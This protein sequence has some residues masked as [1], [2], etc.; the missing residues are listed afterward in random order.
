MYAIR[1]YYEIESTS[2]FESEKYTIEI[3]SK[4]QRRVLFNKVVLTSYEEDKIYTIMFSIAQSIGI[5]YYSS[6]SEYLLEETRVY[7][8]QLETKGRVDLKGRNNFV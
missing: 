7:T 5:G 8:T 1:S 4:K 6:Q 2:D 3:D